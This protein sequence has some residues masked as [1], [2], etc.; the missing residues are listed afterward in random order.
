LDWISPDTTRHD[1]TAQDGT[2]RKPAK[3]PSSNLGELW[4]RLPLVPSIVSTRPGWC[5][6]RRAVNP[7][8]S[9]VRR[10]AEGS[11][12]SSPTN[13]PT[14]PWS[15]GSGRHPLKVEK[16]VRLPSGLLRFD[17]GVAG[18]PPAL[19]RP[20]GPVRYRGLRPCGRAGAQPSFISSEAVVQLPGPQFGMSTPGHQFEGR[21]RH[22]TRT[23]IAVRLRV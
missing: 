22:G 14:A 6:S 5:S 7:L 3:R 16:G 15:T 19:I 23:G 17:S 11:T 20:A 12:P 4:V 10:M 13:S 8:P 21:R 1:T 2:I 9:I 18:A